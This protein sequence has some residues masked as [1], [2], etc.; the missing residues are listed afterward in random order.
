MQS[1]GNGHLEKDMRMNDNAWAT[2]LQFY[3]GDSESQIFVPTLHD[4][5]ERH[6][7]I[8]TRSRTGA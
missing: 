2:V 4:H 5:I 1:T 7:R 6:V 3:R 8:L